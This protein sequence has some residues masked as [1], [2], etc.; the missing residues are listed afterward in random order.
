MR[1]GRTIK[2]LAAALAVA[3]GANGQQPALPPVHR[4]GAIVAHTTAPVASISAIRV[5]S[6]GQLLLDDPADKRLVL[7]DSTLTR[8]TPVIDTVGTPARSYPRSAGELIPFAGD[9][10]LYLDP[11]S[12]AFLVIAPNGAIARV[13]SVPPSLIN[14]RDSRIVYGPGGRV[15]WSLW[16]QHPLPDPTVSGQP[17]AFP[18]PDTGLIIRADLVSHRLDT[19]AVFR[20]PRAFPSV[21]TPD[22]TGFVWTTRTLNPIE[23]SDG[24][25]ILNDGTIAI[26]RAQDFHIDWL[27]PD[28]GHEP[29]PKLPH[30]WVRLTDSVKVAL[31]DSL[32]RYYADPRNQYSQSTGKN[33]VRRT[34]TYA[35]NLPDPAELPDYLPPFAAV[36]GTD[37][38]GNLWIREFTY[39]TSLEGPIFDVVNRAGHMIDRVQIPDGTT[40]Q[41]WGPGVVYLS[42]RD[43]GT[44]SLMRARIR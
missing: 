44:T 6:D 34:R 31:V 35:P 27:T 1:M 38:E 33:G 3:S 20:V 36:Q 24:W 30:L 5:L 42:S 39:G 2:R 21:S 15:L 37:A 22:S 17:L 18:V 9:S 40:L 28:G 7:L 32:R 14:N 41:G 12:Q 43:G 11:T 19:V 8:V 4:V 10:S 26:T 25:G 13:M 16:I 23:V 29:S